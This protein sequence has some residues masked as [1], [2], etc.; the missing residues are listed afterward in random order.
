MLTL[1]RRHVTDFLNAETRGALAPRVRDAHRTLLNA[2]G[3]GGSETVW[4][5][6]LLDPNDALLADLAQTAAEIRERADVLLCIGIGGSYLGAQAVI[7]ALTPTLLKPDGPEILFAGHHL[8]PRYHTE[9]FKYLDGKSVYVNVI[10]KSGSTLE[11]SLAFRFARQFV[12]ERFDDPGRRIIVTTGPEGGLLN[13]L[14][15]ANGYRKYV[16]PDGVG[17]R[18]SVLTPVGLLPIAAAGIDIRSL[19]YGAVDL[20]RT[21]NAPDAEHAALDYAADRYLFHET[22]YKTELMAV[23]EPRLKGIGAWWQQLFGESE[24]KQHRGLFPSVAQYTTDLH[25]LGQYVQQGQRTLVEL[26]LRVEGTQGP[27]VS[28]LADNTDQLNYLAGKSYAAI[29]E[30]AYEATAEAHAEGDVPNWTL[31]LGHLDAQTIGAVLYFFEHA[32]SVS[33]YLLDVNPFNQP[34]VENYK[35]K[36]FS[37][38]GRPD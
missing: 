10:S 32:V 2:S 3:A 18:F 13:P 28:E 11:P 34:G 20:A 36:M 16:I 12:E 17:G 26:F 1:D 14:R 30:V 35:Q 24:G 27:V 25:S 31:T 5:T 38:L 22:G 15:D 37:R 9:L 8:S 4:R 7:D 19:F 33:G 21:L 23:M 29:N 6:M